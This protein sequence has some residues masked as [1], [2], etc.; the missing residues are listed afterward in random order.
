MSGASGRLVWDGALAPCLDAP[1]LDSVGEV[2]VGR[3]GGS[4]GAGAHKNED[5]ALV[6]TGRSWVVAAVLDAHG[7]S[8]SATAMLALLE[9]HRAVLTAALDAGDPRALPK[10]QAAL[11]AL[12]TDAGT[13][14]TMAAVAGETA[15][16]VACQSGPHL[17][18]LSIGDNMLYLCHPE[19]AALGQHSLTVRNFYE[20]IGARSS[21]VGPV[22]AFSTG[23]R[24]LRQGRSTIALLTD[25]ILE[26]G[27][28]RY[29][30][31]AAVAAALTG[32][33]TRDAVAHLL[34][35]ARAADAVDSCTVIAWTVDNPAPAL[36]PSA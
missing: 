7:G 25:G 13:A 9:A 5:A 10:L 33:P 35:G 12:L 3:F 11:V 24:A 15:C 32:G 4:T 31:P 28:R 1:A 14:A 27:D 34:E 20:W 8:A 23:I 16:L 30:D 29:E 22:P 21:L 6:W 2:V 18:W 26:M 17:F 19:L 36:M